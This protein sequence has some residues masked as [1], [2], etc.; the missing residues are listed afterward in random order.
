MCENIP[1][2]FSITIL[3][4]LSSKKAIRSPFSA[5]NLRATFSIK[6]ILL[7]VVSFEVPKSFI[8]TTQTVCAIYLNTYVHIVYMVHIV[9]IVCSRSATNTR[10]RG[11]T[12]NGCDSIMET[13]K[14]NINISQPTPGFGKA[15]VVLEIPKQDIDFLYKVFEIYCDDPGEEFYPEEWMSNTISSTIKDMKQGIREMV[16]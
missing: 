11:T 15:C 7:S 5:L 2:A 3:P 14:S 8:N 4:S 9:H 12:R 10:E 13:P 6:V 16:I 1:Y